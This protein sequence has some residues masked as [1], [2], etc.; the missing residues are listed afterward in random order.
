MTTTTTTTSK[1]FQFDQ[2]ELQNCIQEFKSANQSTTALSKS[3]NDNNSH[4][5]SIISI[6]SSIIKWFQHHHHYQQQQQQHSSNNNNNN[7]NK[8][9]IMSSCY[10]LY[11]L[12]QSFYERSTSHTY[13][14][15][16]Y[17]NFVQNLKFI[18]LHNQE[19]E[20]KLSTNITHYV[21]INQFTDMLDYELPYFDSSHSF[22]DD[23]ENDDDDDDNG[24]S[25]FWDDLSL[26]GFEIIFSDNVY[27]SNN[28]NN[29]DDHDD[30]DNT[31]IDN[32]IEKV[33]IKDSNIEENL[34]SSTLYWDRHRNKYH[35]H[36]R[37]LRKKKG[38]DDHEN[39][40]HVHKV[41][42]KFLYHHQKVQHRH[43]HHHDT[44]WLIQD[45]KKHES[46]VGKTKTDSVNSIGGDGVD[47]Y[48][49][50][51]DL[52][53]SNNNWKTTL[54]WATEDNPD[55]VAIVHPS[56]DQV[57]INGCCGDM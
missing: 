23:N 17:E 40:K 3:D 49:F 50:Q 54:D 22:P 45:I 43:H 31:H 41:L 10:K 25:S 16:R 20:S 30:N 32:N 21:T 35:Q 34:L 51:Y 12:H 2:N 1:P 48:L 7:N 24:F 19:Y 39:K 47:N 33:S 36:H 55:G 11:L 5:T 53:T 27:T 57:R 38:N 6:P 18:H 44:N 29:N 4:G 56:I 28:N 42:Q 14:V 13:T 9:I 52:K 37:H 26:D 15:G 46:Y 8:R